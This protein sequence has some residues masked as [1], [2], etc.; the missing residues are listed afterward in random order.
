MYGLLNK[1][2]EREI[3]LSKYPQVICKKSH[4]IKKMYLSYST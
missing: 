2:S 1:C 3:K 4:T